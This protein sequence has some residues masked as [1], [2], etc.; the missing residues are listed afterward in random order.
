MPCRRRRG[1]RGLGA[2]KGDTTG[3]MRSTA[4]QGEHRTGADVSAATLD[5][6]SP[7]FGHHGDETAT[8]HSEHC[9]P[10]SGAGSTLDRSTP[11]RRVGWASSAATAWFSLAH[12]GHGAAGTVSRL[13][14]S[15]R[16]PE[17]NLAGVAHLTDGWGPGAPRH[18]PQHLRAAHRPATFARE[19][20]GRQRHPSCAA[21]RR[22]PAHQ[23]ASGALGKAAQA[24]GQAPGGLEWS[25]A[26]RS[27]ERTERDCASHAMGVPVP[28]SG[29]P[30][31]TEPLGRP[32]RALP[33]AAAPL[34]DRRHPSVSGQR[35][36]PRR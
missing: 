26:S 13:A 28:R 25:G 12:K 30:S 4:R 21:R 6:R 22:S 34:T 24:A 5:R 32:C 23:G 31:T 36:Q 1:A 14:A 9:C 35:S 17:E 33:G 29:K 2:V 3:R 7:G 15:G 18:T 19:S 8:R 10:A 11:P 16:S 27:P 20:A